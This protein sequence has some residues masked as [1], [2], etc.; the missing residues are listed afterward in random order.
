[1][2]HHQKG[3]IQVQDS[4]VAIDPSDVRQVIQILG[5]AAEI[6][7]IDERRLRTLSGIANLLD[8]DIWMWT[9]TRADSTGNPVPVAMV[10]GGWRDEQQHLAL[11]NCL[12]RSEVHQ[13]IYNPMLAQIRAAHTGLTRTRR[14]L[15]PDN[16]FRDTEMA[17]SIYPPTGMVDF[18]L[19]VVPLENNGFSGLGV[20]RAIGKPMFGNRERCLMHLMFSELDW[21]HRHKADVP[22]SDHVPGLP[23]RQ[24]QV[25]LFLLSGLSSK[26]IA[27]QMGLSLHTVNDHLKSLHRRFNVSSRGELLS[28]FFAGGAIP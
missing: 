27:D 15:L 18:M 23:E 6:Q 26:Q 21:L 2:S 22:A 19:S 11:V 9:C 25:L 13:L 24:R 17:R 12:A 28:K 5:Q 1:M 4:C 8:A 20:H 14:D 16:Q 10:G 3:A 7:S